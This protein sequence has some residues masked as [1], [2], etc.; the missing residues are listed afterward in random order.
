MANRSLLSLAALWVLLWLL[1]SLLDTAT[2]LHDST[3]PAWQAAMVLASSGISA[4][5]IIAVWTRFSVRQKLLLAP[6]YL[7]GM[8]ALHY[9]LRA[10]LF[11]LAGSH[12]DF[13][14]V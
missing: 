11:A 9:G 7:A 14:G 13:H 12:Y 5:L 4:V 3:R 6:A 1:V 2:Y 10:S 8:I